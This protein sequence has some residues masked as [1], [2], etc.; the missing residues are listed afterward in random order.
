MCRWLA[1]SGSPIYLEELI[2]KPEHSLIDQSLAAR[3]TATATNADGFGVGWYGNRSS[4]GLYRDVQPAW[5]D[6]NLRDLAGQ[7]EA[8]LFLAHV[9]SATVPPVQQTNCHPFRYGKW[10][11]MHNGSIRQFADI[12]RDLLLAVAPGL[13]SS[14]E[15]ST[16]SELMF[17]LALTF[18]LEIDPIA[19]VEKM[20]DVV[21]PEAKR[22]NIH[23]PSA[24]AHR[25][26]LPVFITVR[27]STLWKTCTPATVGS[28]RGRSRSSPNPWTVSRTTGRRLPS[29][30]SRSSKMAASLPNR[31]SRNPWRLS[32]SKPYAGVCSFRSRVKRTSAR[33]CAWAAMR[34]SAT[35]RTRLD[36]YSIDSRQTS[37]IECRY[38]ESTPCIVTASSSDLMRHPG[39]RPV[40]NGSVELWPDAEG[41]DLQ[42]LA[43][44][45]QRRESK[46]VPG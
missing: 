41:H 24:T 21:E 39:S 31:S 3:V 25:V 12:R 14:I 7:I 34:R 43:R 18:G 11:F 45:A 15:G 32:S 16:D 8:S 33:T 17:Y 46:E 36:N 1:Y 2:F 26:V 10:L 42:C 27:V 20:V 23:T 5:N 4:P 6:S 44:I 40:G 28:K 38:H 35:T 30:P 22:K 13:F 29:R 37:E 19:G 9:R